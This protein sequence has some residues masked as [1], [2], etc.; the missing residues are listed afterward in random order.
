MAPETKQA[1][2]AKLDAMRVKVAYPDEWRT[3]EAVNIEESLAA[4]LLSASIAETKRWLARVGQPVDR[5]EWL[6][7]PQEVNA[8]YDPSNNE[9]VMMAGMLQP[10]Y[11]DPEADLA[12]NYGAIGAII[13]H[14]LTH[15]YDQGGSQFDAKGNLA[16]WWTEEDSA[17]FDMLTGAVAAQYDAIEVLPGLFVDGDLT[18]GE[19]IADLGGMQIAYDALQLALAESGDPGR[20]DG[21]TQDQRFFLATAFAWSMEVRDEALRTQ[22]ETDF[23]APEAVRGVQP[24]RNMDAFYEAFGIEPDEPMYLPP[25]DRIVIW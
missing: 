22:V 11:F 9:F 16:D 10:P 13:G 23:H 8:Y 15:G 25:E 21:L 2:L 3:Y 12:S 7:L 17:K 14:E 24:A 18:I 4:S 19:D 1:A 6:A 5:D 20:I